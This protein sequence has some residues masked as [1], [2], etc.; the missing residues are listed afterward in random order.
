MQ[1]GLKEGA[2]EV[3]DRE[4]AKPLIVKPASPDLTLA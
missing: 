3:K 1:G 4:R 2:L